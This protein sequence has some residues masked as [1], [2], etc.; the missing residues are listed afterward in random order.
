[1]KI[2][3]NDPRV[4]KITNA[5]S[6]LKKIKGGTI[7]LSEARELRDTVKDCIKEIVFRADK[8][9]SDYLNSFV[10]ATRDLMFQLSEICSTV[11]DH[12]A[13]EKQNSFVQGELVEAYLHYTM[14]SESYSNAISKARSKSN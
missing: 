12:K 13:F 4:S 14:N 5:T 1:M 7:T 10:P 6:L 2:N 3:V 8:M 9:N 11:G